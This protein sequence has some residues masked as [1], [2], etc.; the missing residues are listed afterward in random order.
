[1]LLDHLNEQLRKSPLSMDKYYE[2]LCSYERKQLG[3]QINTRK[4]I[5]TIT[6]ARRE[7]IL[8]ILVTVWHDKRKIL[9]LR[10]AAELLGALSFLA[11]DCPAAKY[12]YISLQHSV[13]KALKLNSKF[14]FSSVKFAKFL[15]FTTN[16]YKE[17]ANFF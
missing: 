12:L 16:K 10:E 14:A 2:S 3:K 11:Q 8:K 17:I 5:V 9:T 4:L 1:M 13:Y 7:E 15:E 6:E